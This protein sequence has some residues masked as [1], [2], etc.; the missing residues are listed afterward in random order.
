MPD[1]YKAK[2]NLFVALAPVASVYNVEVPFFK[3]LS[4]VWRELQFIIL[5]KGL[6][7]LYDSNWWQEEAE[8]II[9][10]KIS[11]VVCYGLIKYLA[12]A[13]IEVDNMAR[14]NVFLKDFPS[15]EGYQNLVWYAQSILKQGFKRFDYGPIENL[16]KYGQATPPDYPL[17]DFNLPT[18]LVSG[19]YDELADPDDVAWLHDQISDHVVFAQQYPLGHLSFLIAKDMSYF[20]DDV[21][22]LIGKYATNVFDSET[23][24][25]IQQ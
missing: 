23:T 15:G 19:S 6:F 14:L 17:Q 5:R 1:Y 10:D 2:V 25:F 20:T 13:N 11:P 21:V 7:D 24:N 12:D 16:K 22:P 3:K 18:A 4:H 9:C 8:K